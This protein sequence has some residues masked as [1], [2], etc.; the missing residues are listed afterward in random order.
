[1][2]VA[3]SSLVTRSRKKTPSQRLG[4]FFQLNS[5][6]GS[7]EIIFDD[8]IRLDTGW[9]DFISSTTG[10][11]SKSKEYRRKGF[12]TYQLEAI[13]PYDPQEWQYI[14]SDKNALPAMWEPLHAM[15][16]KSI[17]QSEEELLN[18]MKTE[19]EYQHY[20]NTKENNL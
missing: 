1:M 19:P 3:S 6:C 18:E 2:E 20:F 10:I 7:E 12:Y 15:T 4:V 9:V 8:E 13:Y 14:G 17:F 16:G 11:S 5:P